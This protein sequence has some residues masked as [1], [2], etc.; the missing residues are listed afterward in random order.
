MVVP[1]KERVNHQGFDQHEA[2]LNPV[3]STRS[4]RSGGRHLLAEGA[5]WSKAIYRDCRD[6]LRQHQENPIH[7]SSKINNPRV[8]ERLSPLP[9]PRPVVNLGKE[10][11]VP[12]EHEGTRDSEVFRNTRSRS[13]YSESK[14]KSHALDQ[15]FLLLRGNWDLQKKTPIVHDST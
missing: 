13:Q 4:G 10:Q 14:E 12:E 7:I 8:F 11:Q 15:T 1:N 2:S 5:K 6:F 9:W 3:A